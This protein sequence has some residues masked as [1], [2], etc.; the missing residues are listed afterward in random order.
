MGRKIVRSLF[1]PSTVARCDSATALP[2]SAVAFSDEWFPAQQ[3]LTDRTSLLIRDLPTGEKLYFRVRA[4]NIAGASAA[5]TLGQPV[6]IR[7]IVQ[8]PRICLPRSLR[9]KVMKVVGEPV[10]FMIPFQGKPRPVV[11]W[12]KDEQ[13]LNLK[14]ITIRNSDTDTIFFIRKAERTHSGSYQLQVQ[15]ENTKD[16]ASI[17]IQVIDKPGPPVNVKIGEVWGVN[18]ALSWLPPKDNGNCEV[19]GYTVQKADKKTMEWFT[20]YEHYRRAQCSV[21]E[22]VVGNEYFFRVFTENMCGLSD[23]ACLSKDSVYIQKPGT[24]YKPPSYK[25][26]DFTEPPKFTRPLI[27]RSVICGYNTTLS[28]ALRG[29]PKPKVIW[30]K[31]QIDLSAD[32]R[33]RMFSNQGVLTLEIRKPCSIDAGIYSCQATNLLGEAKSDCRLEVRVS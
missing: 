12:L 24:E 23:E 22:L 16:T 15:I 21:S 4:V 27:N 13:P 7:E 1:S 18:V 5:A 30:Y 28:C 2:D 29:S 11:T 9:Q 26:H 33:Y 10:N 25:Q 31:N 3:G 19:T 6:T 32:P 14:S 17:H 8:R 20:V